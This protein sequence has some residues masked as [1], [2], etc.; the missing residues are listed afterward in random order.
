MNLF[1]FD[2]IYQQGSEMPAN[3]LSRNAVDAIQFDLSTYAQEQDKD[4]LLQNL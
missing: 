1:S 2:I 3:F 4:E